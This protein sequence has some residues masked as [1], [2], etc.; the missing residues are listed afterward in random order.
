MDLHL[1]IPSMNNIYDSTYWEK[2]KKDEQNRSNKMYEYS[3]KP[4]ESGVVSKTSGSAMFNRKF[5]SE[6]NDNNNNNTSNNVMSIAGEEFD[7][8]AAGLEDFG[9]NADG[10]YDWD[11]YLLGDGITINSLRTYSNMF[12]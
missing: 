2:V 8:A 5:Y 7:I 9:E 3:K 12:Q 1:D 4:Y 11:V 6:I 10:S